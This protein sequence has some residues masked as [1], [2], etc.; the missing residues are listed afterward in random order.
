MN[1][2]YNRIIDHRIRAVA[3]LCS[4]STGKMIQRIHVPPGYRGLG[5]GSALLKQIL[6]DADREK[7][8]LYLCIIPKDGGLNELQLRHWYERHGFVQH[9]VLVHKRIPNKGV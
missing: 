3:D 2:V 8:T 1:N 6:A 4:H 9:N 5:H 7:V